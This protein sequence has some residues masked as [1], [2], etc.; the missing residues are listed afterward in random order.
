MFADGLFKPCEIDLP[1]VS[2]TRTSTFAIR[3]TGP[4]VEHQRRPMIH[5]V[6]LRK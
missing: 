4:E 1:V 6:V 2:L 3:W 5:Y